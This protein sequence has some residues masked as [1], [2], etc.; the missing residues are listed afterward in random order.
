MLI[1]EVLADL[2]Q[3]GL[4]NG[5][6]A[7]VLLHA[8]TGEH[9]HVDH[10][11]LDAGGHPQGGVLHVRRLLAENGPQQLL[12]WRELGFA[13]RRHLADEDVAR[14]DFG[15]DVDDAR[16]IELGQRANADA[17]N[18][19]GDL[20][21]TEPGVACDAGQFLN[22][23]AGEAVVLH[24]PLRNQNGVL[25]VVAVPRHEGDPHVLAERQFTHVHRRPVG[26]NVA[27]LD[28]IARRNQGPLIDA[29]VLVGTG[30]FDQ[31]VD[32][33]PGFVGLGFLLRYPH[34]DASGIN[35]VHH[36]APAGGDADP[37]IPGHMAFDASPH[38]G[39]FGTQGGHGLALHVRSHQRPVGVIVLQEGDQRGGDGDHL[40]GGDI[41]VVDVVRLHLGEL[42][43]MAHVNQGFGKGAVVVQP[44][45][46][47]GDD[48]LRFVDSRKVLDVVRDLAVHHLAVGGL[49]KA[50]L[51]GS[52]VG[53]QAVDQADVRTFRG[54]DGANPPVVGR[55]HVANLESGPLP[56][57]AARP[58]SRYPPLVRDLGKRVVLVHELG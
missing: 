49:Q 32:V 15:A 6:G 34:D 24:H 53:R 16:L 56:G 23:N 12:L 40:L 57:Q 43:L 4:L 46:G 27:R 52:G 36:A 8:I 54:L 39:L 2:C 9:A 41:H 17:R 7:L 20:L 38:K 51:V 31:V 13:L 42:V 11:A 22:V 3:F 58:Q 37:G 30:E 50:V 19:A 18:V 44:G 21:R 25:E 5:L 26:Q 47:L 28:L 10:R 1:V 45:T 29:G 48:V 35:A 14:G 33:H 55:M